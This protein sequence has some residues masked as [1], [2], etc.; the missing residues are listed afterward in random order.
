MEDLLQE[1]ETLYYKIIRKIEKLNCQLEEN[2]L[3]NIEYER[4]KSRRDLLQLE[5][6][7][8]MGAINEMR[9]HL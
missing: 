5:S 2:N 8:V 1:Y 9:K 4:L 7:E 3:H 6:W